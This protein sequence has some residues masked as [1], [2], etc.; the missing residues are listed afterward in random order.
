MHPL[1]PPDAVEPVVR[2]VA[3]HFVTDGRQDEVL[4]VRACVCVCVCVCA[5]VRACVRACVCVCVCVCIIKN[6]G[7]YIIKCEGEEMRPTTWS[8]TAARTRCR[9]MKNLCGEKCRYIY[10]F[11]PVRLKKELYIYIYIYACV[12]SGRQLL[13]RRGPL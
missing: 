9:N 11:L 3:N 8:L 5:C 6:E 4:C 10:F 13:R 1:V 2:A 12:Y 7:E